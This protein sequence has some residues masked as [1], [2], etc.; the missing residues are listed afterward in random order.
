MSRAALFRLEA[1]ALRARAHALDDTLIRGQYFK[2][3]DH[4]SM[5]AAGLEL[6]VFTLISKP[7]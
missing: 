1:D 6:Q 2:L 5:L 4:W 3:A 7:L